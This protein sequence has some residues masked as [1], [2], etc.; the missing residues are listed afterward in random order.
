MQKRIL[1]LITILI[2]IVFGCKETESDDQ[3]V[4]TIQIVDGID[5]NIN[6]STIMDSIWSVRLNS[7]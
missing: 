2:F 4:E 6:M 1:F 3:L 7:N 5:Q